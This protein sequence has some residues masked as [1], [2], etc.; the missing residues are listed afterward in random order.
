MQNSLDESSQLARPL[1]IRVIAGSAGLMAVL[2]AVVLIH[3]SKAKLGY[4]FPL[5]LVGVWG[6][7]WSFPRSERESEA[8]RD[9]DDEY[10]Y[11]SG[12]R[13]EYCPCC[14]SP[15]INQGLEITTCLLCEWD[16]APSPAEQPALP[17]A[18]ENVRRFLW[19]YSPDS[20]PEW[21]SEAPRPEELEIKRDL[22]A[23]YG[24]IKSAGEG[25]DAELW[26]DALVLEAELREY[27]IRR[28]SDS[29]AE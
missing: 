22:I 17:N 24:R 11:P 9:S 2:S 13:R 29:G 14:G 6:V 19:I 21:R 4:A 25:T 5:F 18:R 26:P 16:T 10:L 20:L 27:E 7:V 23:Q 28:I 8:T 3:M 12:F 15:T 1:L